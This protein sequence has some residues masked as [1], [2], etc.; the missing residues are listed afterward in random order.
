[1]C[2]V[3]TEYDSFLSW[4]E[5]EEALKDGGYRV[6]DSALA[7]TYLHFLFKEL[8]FLETCVY[9]RSTADQTQ[10]LKSKIVS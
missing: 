6:R 4:C 1:M 5:R 7:R 8:T 10:S 3:L 9:L 2:T